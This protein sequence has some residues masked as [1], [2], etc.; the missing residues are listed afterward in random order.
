MDEGEVP[1]PRQSVREGLENRRRIFEFVKRVP[2]AHLRGVQRGI[3]LP[4]GTAEYHLHALEDAG[5]VRTVMDGNLKR[6]FAADFAFEDRAVLSILRKRPIRR[7]VVALLEKKEM[8]HRDL[9]AAAGV[10]PPTLTYHLSR[11]EGANL[12]AVRRDGRFAYIRL[13]DPK[14]AMRILIAH[15]QS[16]ADAAV[17]RF[18]ETFGGTAAAR[19]PEPDPVKVEPSGV[20][21]VDVQPAAKPAFRLIAPRPRA[22]GDE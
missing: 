11:L 19:Y 21:V 15:G 6:Y 2:G 18:L 17:D 9:A 3:G 4:Y 20:D 12:V 1:P 5:L 8:T 22:D 13:L 16:F 10:K 14:L 7:V